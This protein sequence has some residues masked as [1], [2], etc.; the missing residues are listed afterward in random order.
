M[1]N[2]RR[3]RWSEELIGEKLQECV[4]ALG[5]DRMPTRS[6]IDKYCG[7]YALSNK[8]D[9]TYGYYGWAKKLGLEM[10][11]SDTETGKFGEAYAAQWLTH[12][13]YK[14]ERMTTR[15]PYDLLINGTIKAD[16]KYSHLYK[17]K[18]G[19]AF[20]S[21]RLEKIYPTCDVYLAISEDPH[22]NKAVYIIPAK[23]VKQKQ[24]SMGQKSSKYDKYLNR[25]DILDR[26]LQA[27]SDVG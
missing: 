8:V 10:K 23:N 17:T 18:E 21:F 19:F 24:M 9:K 5:I 13:G 3:A 14:V 25:T 22:G 2:I 27:Y 16:V 6:E 15:H 26:L 1:K 20:Y 4:L 11:K 7:D 12:R